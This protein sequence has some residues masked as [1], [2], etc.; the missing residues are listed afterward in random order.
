L[1]NELPEPIVHPSAL[2][3]AT[4]KCAATGSRGWPSDLLNDLVGLREQGGWH[5]DPQRLRCLQVHHKLELACPQDRQVGR[6]LA[7]QDAA[8]VAGAIGRELEVATAATKRDI[9]AAFAGLA[10]MRADALLLNPEALFYD[11]RAPPSD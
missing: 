6:F 2:T 5:F 10:R 1:A 7:L 4:I 8:E 9:V 11:R 3:D